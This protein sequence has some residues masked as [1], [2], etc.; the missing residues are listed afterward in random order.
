MLLSVLSDKGAFWGDPSTP[1]RSA[2]DDKG[3]VRSAQDDKGG[4][5]SAQDDKG[6]VR[7]A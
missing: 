4:V 7:S 3:G 5:H 6:G 1:L 2:Q